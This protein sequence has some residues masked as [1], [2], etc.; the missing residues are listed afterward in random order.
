MAMAQ[1][2]LAGLMRGLSQSLRDKQEFGLRERTLANQETAGQES[3]SL[4]RDKYDLNRR[5]IE[6]MMN[7]MNRPG[8]DET[9]I[10]PDQMGFL[11]DAYGADIPSGPMPLPMVR[12][13]IKVLGNKHKMRKEEQKDFKN[14]LWTEAKD[15][16]KSL[17]KVNDSLNQDDAFYDDTQVADM[18]KQKDEFY[19]RLEKIKEVADSY[20]I[21]LPFEVFT[22][23]KDAM[24][25]QPEMAPM[26]NQGQPQNL[27]GAGLMKLRSLLERK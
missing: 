6:S 22:L 24:N 25:Q 26:P 8:G 19:A 18:Q 11:K 14:K 9:M 2:A 1:K 13:Q 4:A 21:K 16:R 7:K 3:R 5:Y 10:S 27:L 17:D 12:E 20:S 15:I 23:E